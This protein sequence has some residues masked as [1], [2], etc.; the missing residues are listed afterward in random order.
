V[1][2]LQLVSMVVGTPA[3]LPRVAASLAADGP[4]GK[5]GTQFFAALLPFL[6]H[7][8]REGPPPATPP[9]AGE[10]FD[11]WRC[12]MNCWDLSHDIMRSRSLE[13][14]MLP[15]LVRDSTSQLVLPE[16]AALL[17]RMQQAA[18]CS[19]QP[20]PREASLA[21][22]ALMDT[23]ARLLS[24]SLYSHREALESMAQAPAAGSRG[25]LQGQLLAL[26]HA[27]CD[28]ASNAVWRVLG[29][30]PAA[31]AVL[32]AAA[33]AAG[34]GTSIGTSDFQF[35]AQNPGMLA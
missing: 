2:L 27:Q 11:E 5:P 4:G 16:M 30:L 8:A 9:A 6:A 25:Q 12:V 1:Q 35:M 18:A 20:P 29:A 28:R 7:L 10:G 14:I 19:P 23:A 3:L 15:V 32:M 17:A 34:H 22:L 26:R 24:G 31:A 33:G 21:Q 13:L